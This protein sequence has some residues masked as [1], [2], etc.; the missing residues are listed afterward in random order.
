MMGQI[1]MVTFST[2]AIISLFHVS[3]CRKPTER[4][5]G[6]SHHLPKKDGS[7]NVLKDKEFVR[8]YEHIKED[9][10]EL[11]NKD[12]ADK[13]QDIEMEIFYFQLHDMN[14]DKRL[15]GLELLAAMNHVRERENEITHR[16]LQDS[17]EARVALQ[18]WWNEKFEE[19]AQFIDEILREEDLDQDGYL[20]YFEYVLGRER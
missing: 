15:D 13:L 5:S 7:K 14:D 18:A 19:D 2:L 20:N 16:D 9:V 11:Y 17:P 4:H 10:Q 8:D 3:K 6:H 1:F 12:F